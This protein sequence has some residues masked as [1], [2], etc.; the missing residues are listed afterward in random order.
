MCCYRR[1][2][3]TFH[4]VFGKLLPH[5]AE[6]IFSRDTNLFLMQFSSAYRANE[7]NVPGKS[8]LNTTTHLYRIHFCR[9]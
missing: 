6:M 3:K 4:D 8:I 1:I 2:K 5:A 7:I 9:H